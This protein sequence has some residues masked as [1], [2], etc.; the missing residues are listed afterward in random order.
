MAA[1]VYIEGFSLVQGL[2]YMYYI[3]YVKAGND[4]NAR[5]F[6]FLNVTLKQ[7]ECVNVLFNCF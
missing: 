5:V 7:C 3:E 4:S 2:C 6:L 1:A